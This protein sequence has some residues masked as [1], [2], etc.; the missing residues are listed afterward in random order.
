MT[1]PRTTYSLRT[2]VGRL[3]RA[4]PA[5][6]AVIERLG[7]CRFT[8]R[9]DGTHFD[10]LVRAI[11][12]QQL[13]GKAAA[14]IHERLRG[15]YGGRDPLPSELLATPEDTLRG[16]G[17]SRQKMSYLVDLARH[18]DQELLPLD[19]VEQMPD[20]EV[21]SALTDVR[22]VG[23]WTAQIF[24][25]FRLGRPDVVPENDLGIQKGVQITYDLPSLPSPREVVRIA[26]AWAP[27][28]S[29]ASWYMWRLL[30]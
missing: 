22:G 11:L 9:S 15:L 12:S 27:Y 16:C 2:A 3:K 13:S 28:R 25:L 8:L 5:L 17:L 29:V 1:A 7:P 14:T 19:R 20:D 21:I 4:D 26:D 6:R 23:R 10:A 30:D 24:L 18:V